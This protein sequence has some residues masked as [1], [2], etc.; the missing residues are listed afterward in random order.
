MNL[1][2]LSIIA[3]VALVAACES[4]SKK[5]A[6]AGGSGDNTTAAAPSSTSGVQKGS[7]ADFVANVGDRVFFDY[8]KSD[9]KGD[10]RAQ[11]AKWV[12]FLKANPTD[13]LTIEGHCDERGTVEYNLALGDRRATAVKNFL[14]AEGVDAARLK[15]IS[16]GKSRPA[17]MGHTDDA[18]KQNRRGVGVVQAPGS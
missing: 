5:E 12:A 3:A 7:Q 14:V 2:Y 16:Y 15:T 13:K 6:T 17:V 18:W 4:P 1:R 8:D 11:L 10:A 9:L